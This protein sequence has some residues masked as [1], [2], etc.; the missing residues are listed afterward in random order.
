MPCQIVWSPDERATVNGFVGDL[1]RRRIIYM[2]IGRFGQEDARW[3][4]MRGRYALLLEPT[5]RVNNEYRRIGT[6][7]IPEDEGMADGGRE[8]RLRSFN[9]DTVEIQD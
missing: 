9:L 1:I 8:G 7:Q 3:G 5:G 4:D 2:Q 6:A